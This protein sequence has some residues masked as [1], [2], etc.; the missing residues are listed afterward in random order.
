MPKEKITR[1]QKNL[2]RLLREKRSQMA[3]RILA[4][5]KKKLRPSKH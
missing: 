2:S 1:R 3:D 4:K 5:N